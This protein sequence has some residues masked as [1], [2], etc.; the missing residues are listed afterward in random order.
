MLL[1]V[2]ESKFSTMKYHY[3]LLVKSVL[4]LLFGRW[5]YNKTTY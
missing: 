5:S 2:G 4:K 3:F 1:F